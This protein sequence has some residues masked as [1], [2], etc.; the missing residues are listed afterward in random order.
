MIKAYRDANAG[1]FSLTAS[2]G[3][4]TCETPEL[5]G[6]QEPGEP[7]I[8]GP[9]PAPEPECLFSLDA[10][11]LETQAGLTFGASMTATITNEASV[12]LAYREQIIKGMQ[13][14]QWPATTYQAA[15]G[16]TDDMEFA[17]APF[18]AQD[19]RGFV[20]FSY[21]AGDNPMA[22][23]F[24]DVDQPVL[25]FYDDW[26]ATC[27]IEPGG[28][29]LW[30][31]EAMQDLIEHPDHQLETRI[32]YD[33]DNFHTMPPILKEQLRRGME[34]LMDE[35]IPTAEEAFKYCDY[36]PN[37]PEV[38]TQK[39][40]HKSGLKFVYFDFTQG[41]NGFGFAYLDAETEMAYYGDGYLASCNAPLLPLN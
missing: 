1:D 20:R 17:V 10:E 29:C 31:E 28:Q 4:G 5:P 23:I 15:V 27:D 38:S 26:M 35:S 21:H 40:T 18:K 36:G 34:Q 19:G 12:P 25:S 22:F 33:K 11:E 3:S 30:E 13:N 6:P 41:E 9:V 16:Y 2:C 39:F 7:P 32:Y 24:A 14:R 8:T 37:H